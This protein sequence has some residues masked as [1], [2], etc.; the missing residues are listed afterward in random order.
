[1]AAETACADNHR[2]ATVVSTTATTA[3]PVNPS[4]HDDYDYDEI[5]HPKQI[6]ESTVSII[7]GETSDRGW[8]HS[9]VHW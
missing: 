2:Q 6:I 8:G 5:K 1:M 9:A 7:Y 4:P 3:A